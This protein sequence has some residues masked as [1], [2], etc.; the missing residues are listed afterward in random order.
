[1]RPREIRECFGQLSIIL[2]WSCSPC[3]P[4]STIAAQ[5]DYCRHFPSHHF[6]F[7]ESVHP[8]QLIFNLEIALDLVRLKSSPVLHVVCTRTWDESGYALWCKSM[9]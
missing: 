3:T 5:C 9:V 6:R 2:H 4:I 1:M 8:E 7:R